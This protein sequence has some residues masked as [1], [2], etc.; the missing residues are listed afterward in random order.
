MNIVTIASV[1]SPAGHSM[2]LDVFLLKGTYY[3]NKT[4]PGIWGVVLGLCCSYTHKN[5][6]KSLYMIILVR[7]AFLKVPYLQLPN[8]QV[9]F[10]APC[11][12]GSRGVTVHWSH[13]SVHTS[14]QTSRFGMVQ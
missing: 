4:F 3:E 7:Y 11:Y 13:G 5:F 14:V 12:I 8:E 2:V 9:S 10:S 1:E 6:E